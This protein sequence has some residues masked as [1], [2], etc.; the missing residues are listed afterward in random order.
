MRSENLRMM[1]SREARS[2][3]LRDTPMSDRPRRVGT[4]LFNVRTDLF[5]KR[6]RNQLKSFAA[7]SD[8]YGSGYRRGGTSYTP[9]T[10]SPYGSSP[11]QSGVFSGSSFDSSRRGGAP[12]YG[13]SSYGSSSHQ[14]HSYA[15]SHHPAS[16]WESAS[17]SEPHRRRDPSHT[18]VSSSSSSGGLTG[19]A[20]QDA[21]IERCPD[22]RKYWNDCGT[23]CP[24]GCDTAPI[25]TACR[26]ECV[27]GCFCLPEFIFERAADWR[28]SRLREEATVSG[29]GVEWD[30][31]CDTG[32]PDLVECGSVQIIILV[33]IEETADPVDASSDSARFSE[34]LIP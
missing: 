6:R 2:R 1:S 32:D 17:F 7:A 10:R 34:D 22:R 28:N 11:R 30:G 20:L 12:G 21:N 15:N 29:G 18:P 5:P 24:T 16:G 23:P 13:F 19:L 4:A 25:I 9:P 27:A 8:H 3:R 26:E 31:A 33:L 14:H